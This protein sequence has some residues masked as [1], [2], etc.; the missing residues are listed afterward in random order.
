MAFADAEGIESFRCLELA[1]LH[2]IAVDYA[3]TGVPAVF[4]KN[5]RC[6]NF[7]DF[8]EKPKK[9]AYI[10]EKVL[11]KIFH[12]VKQ[13]RN[14]NNK[15]TKNL[16]YQHHS[17][18]NNKNVK[19]IDNSLFVHGY[20]SFVDEARHLMTD[21]NYSLWQI[22]NQYDVWNEGE[23]ISGFVSDFAA[24]VSKLRGSDFQGRLNIAVNNLRK[25][26]KNEFFDGIYSD[27]LNNDSENLDF[28]YVQKY[29]N[30][31]NNNNNNNNNNKNVDE[32]SN[33]NDSLQ[34]NRVIE[35]E[36]MALQKASA[37]YYVT[38]TYYHDDR[39]LYDNLP[40]LY[41][42]AWIPLECLCQ[43]KMI[44]NRNLAK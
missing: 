15:V 23:L 26:F 28:N 37:W 22:M 4:P 17:K 16:H 13:L 33:K 36:Y 27:F 20:Q 10:S 1:A 39:N 43:I 19:F 35:M 12:R 21:Y 24:R 38:Y 5:L 42:F 44:K 41:S 32:L 6:N 40:P 11:G 18:N 7:P 25:H 9:M 3:K 30:D 31:N 8:M 29:M 34:K 14:R 2:S